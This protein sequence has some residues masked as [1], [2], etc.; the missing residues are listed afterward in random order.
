MPET[1]PEAPP[2]EPETEPMVPVEE[3]SRRVE[4]SPFDPAWPDD[5]PLPPPKAVARFAAA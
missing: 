2:A 4:P 5:L 3:P 1:I